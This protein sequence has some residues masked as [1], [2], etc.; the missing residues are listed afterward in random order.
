MKKPNRFFSGFSIAMSILVLILS[1]VGI[2]GVWY[3][4]LT[5]SRMVVRLLSGVEKTA[6]GLQ[7]GLENSQARLTKMVEITDAMQTATTQVS[8]NISDKGLVLSLFPE[9]QDSELLANV[10]AVQDT[11]KTVRGTL[12]GL[13]DTYRAINSLPFVKLPGPDESQLKAAKDG[14]DK[15]TTLVDQLTTFTGSL[16][17]GASGGFEQAATAIGEIKTALTDLQARLDKA[18]TGLINLQ[19]AAKQAQN[20]IPTLLTLMAIFF[21]LFLIWVAYTQYVVMQLFLANWRQAGQLD[22]GAAPQA[23]PVEPPSQEG[24]VN[25]G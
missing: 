10:R 1:I 23:S 24:D 9:K 5:A 6:L 2:F 14:V 16:R 3:S 21:T 8:Q 7:S 12:T 15:I 19:A 4:T 20:V 22:A 13:M 18:K 25:Q 11:L 17:S